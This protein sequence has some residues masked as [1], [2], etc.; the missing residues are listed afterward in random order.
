MKKGNFTETGFCFGKIKETE[1]KQKGSSAS[2][3]KWQTISGCFDFIG[4]L[5]GCHHQ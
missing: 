4:E 3:H 2:V 5:Q 1:T